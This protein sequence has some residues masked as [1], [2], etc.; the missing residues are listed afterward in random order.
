M[1]MKYIK[2]SS[3]PRVDDPILNKALEQLDEELNKIARVFID[4]TDASQNFKTTGTLEAGNASLGTIGCDEI[5]IADGHGINLQEDIT[6]TGA[7][8]VNQI[9]FLDNLANALAFQEGSNIYQQFITTNGSEAVYFAK[10]VGIGTAAP[11][12]YHPFGGNLVIYSAAQTGMT[13]VSANDEEG[14]LF[15]ADGAAGGS[16][17]PSSMGGIRYSHVTNAMTFS[18]NDSLGMTLGADQDLTLVANLTLSSATSTIT[19]GTDLFLEATNNLRSVTTMNATVVN[20]SNMYIQTSGDARIYRSTSGRKYK[21]KIKDLELDSALIYNIPPRSYNSKCTGD[22]KKRRFH[23]L[24]A[25][26]VEQYYPELIDYNDDHEPESYDSRMLQALM[27]AEVQ[28][29]EVKI[30]ALEARFNN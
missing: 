24:V 14:Y 16:P 8:T 13:I 20:G 22:D 28:K 26:E 15:F 23:G 25:E 27:L 2:Q 1:A 5:T 29:H 19:G 4:W 18:A 6:F 21:D 17:D 3:L 10:K 11:G 30:K 9:K 7:T 12:N